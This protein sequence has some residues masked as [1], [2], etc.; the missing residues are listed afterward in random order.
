MYS[1]GA[2]NPFDFKNIKEMIVKT[3]PLIEP[4]KRKDVVLVIGDTGAGKSTLI[5][6]LLGCKM[7]KKEGELGETLAEVDGEM[8]AKIGHQMKACTFY[9]EIFQSKYNQPNGNIFSYCDFPGFN[10]TGDEET[11]V[12]VSLNREYMVSIANSIKA[13]IVAIP[14]SS[15]NTEGRGKAFVKLVETLTKLFKN[16]N[17]V[18]PS[19]LFVITK[20]PKNAVVEGVI[21]KSNEI[22][23]REVESITKK[24]QKFFSNLKDKTYGAIKNL[25]SSNQ[26][27]LQDLEE[28][29][30][31]KEKK[32]K[33]LRFLELMVQHKENIIIA[34]IFDNGEV[35]KKIEARLK[36]FVQ[37]EKNQFIFNK[38]E[39]DRMQFE[40]EIVKQASIAITI[41][42]DMKAIQDDTQDKKTKLISIEESIKFY[43]DQIKK[44]H[45]Q[46]NENLEELEIQ[47]EIDGLG[48]KINK[49]HE[50]ARLIDKDVQALQSDIEKHNGELKK[51]N[52][53]E[54]VLYWE[55]EI[56]EI[57]SGFLSL[58][59][60]AK[61][62]FY[63]RQGIPFIKD[64]KEKHGNGEL[65]RI[66]YNPSQGKYRSRYAS[67]LGG[68]GNASVK[69]Y[70]EKRIVPTNAVEITHLK[71]RIE[72]KEV[73]IKSLKEQHKGFLN[74]INELKKLTDQM[75]ASLA[76]HQKQKDVEIQVFNEHL[77]ALKSNQI[78]YENQLTDLKAQLQ[79]LEARYDELKGTFNSNEMM[80]ADI[81]E[82]LCFIQGLIHSPFINS[83]LSL[84][85]N[86]KLPQ[87]E[88]A[89]GS[90]SINIEDASADNL[91]GNYSNEKQP[92][93]SQFN[94][95]RSASPVPTSN[96]DNKPT[97]ST[98]LLVPQ[99]PGVKRS[100]S[101]APTFGVSQPS[102]NTLFPA[103]QP[104][105]AKRAVSPAPVSV[106][107][108]IHEDNPPHCSVTEYE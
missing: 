1:Y 22:L 85:N 16:V 95:K 50:S 55:D 42:E 62:E 18:S 19:I 76:K 47:K 68:D 99:Q 98:T 15:F 67:N 82:I 107:K 35:R 21:K 60:R 87:N 43:S 25:V 13:I 6:Y 28:L 61:K 36:T 64:P 48:K 106:R 30:E 63:Y 86:F 7:K 79:Q 75:N 54:P 52:T 39:K 27:S 89:F 38:Y 91:K 97:K 105:V 31:K 77:D 2:E 71:K 11:R 37:V 59:S 74:D 9:P 41:I 44:Q 90:I 46:T 51:I 58:F 3:F 5:N 72:E 49:L 108:E 26:T 94:I 103:Q 80:Y 96:K 24:A 93:S 88:N 34:D 23:D 20:A 4:G 66:E 12:A 45:F 10:D 17:A 53:D 56:N 33:G 57:R 78:N 104:S 102:K 29:D 32:L 83:F 81:Y 65:T 14:A 101:P 84:Y 73:R 69:I 40:E 8:Y 92:N 70:V 100:V